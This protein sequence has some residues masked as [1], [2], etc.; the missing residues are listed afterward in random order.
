LIPPGMTAMSIP[1]N[2]FALSGYAI[3]DGAHV[4]IGYDP[5]PDMGSIDSTRDDGHVHPH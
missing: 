1:T 4:I 2:R 3:T 5:W